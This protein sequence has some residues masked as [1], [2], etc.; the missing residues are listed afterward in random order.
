M[1]TVA[2]LVL[3]G[4]LSRLLPHPPNFV[5]LGALALYSGARLPRGRAWVVP[6]AA[7]AFSDFFLDFGSGRAIVSAVRLT[8]YATFAAIVL[9]GRLARESP[10][11]R[12][13]A[14]LSVAASSLFF[15]TTNFAEWLT[16]PL[17]A[18]TPGGLLA[19][20]AAAIPFFWNTLAADLFGTAVLFGLDALT[21]RQRN[22]RL[23][24][25]VA[26]VAVLALARPGRLDAQALPPASES[27]VVTAT[28]SPEEEKDLG[29]ATTVITRQDIEKS[30]RVTVVELLRSVPALDVVQS[31]SDG[32][33]TSIFLRGTNSTQTLVLV[34]GARVNSAYFPGYDFSGL[35]TENVERI[36]IARGPFS[37]LYGSD[38]IGGVIQI[39]TRPTGEGF[40]GSAAAEGGN[41]GTATASAFLSGSAGPFSAA[42]S[43]RYGNTNGDVPNSNWRENNGSARVG[44]QPGDGVRLGLEGSILSGKVGNPGPIGA[45]NP[46]A[47]GVFREERIALPASLALSSTNHLEGFVA[48]VWSKPEYDDPLGGY[49]SQTDARTLQAQ[50]TDTATL[51]AHTLTAIAMWNRSNVTNT[52]TFG[53]N[54]DGQST[55]IWGIGAQDSVTVGH[56]TVS[57]GIRYD[58]NSQFGGAVSPRGSVSWL[59]KDRRWKVR[60]AGGTGFRAPTV[61][62][63][64]YPYYGNP[65]LQPERSVSWEIGAEA[66]LGSG[67]RAEV[68]YFWNDL[69]DLIVYDFA[70]ATT[71]NIGRARTRGI[72]IGYRQQIVAALAIQATYTYLDAVDRADETPLP[73]RPRNRGSLT[74]LWQ[75][76]TSLSIEARALWVGSRPDS[77]PIT[78]AAV[79][80]PA[81]FRLDLFASWRLGGVSPYLRINNLTDA[82]YDEAAGYPAAGIRAG[83]GVEVKF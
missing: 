42:A 8:V 43:Y 19:C 46:E 76:L 64:Y 66:Y 16:D 45:Q 25:A 72:E 26:A 74:L 32:S 58:G 65:D 75:P 57:G 40:S 20:Y 15:L 18:G 10:R 28:A 17:Y 59:S 48:S 11:P 2:L 23:A 51:G 33:L 60:A 50:V 39:F 6:V 79:V 70:S 47:Y 37:A 52:D 5:A 22:R 1:T 12:H 44:W 68:T 78:S 35:T 36:E 82:S 41:A 24:A 29:V 81:Y 83:G 55:T 38:A 30:G 77:D 80:D 53:T 13:L 56:F 9:A 63:L 34:D 21:G 27:V 14:V 71:E 7:M 62:E 4:A 49:S 67:G 3:L 69:K 54:L 73:R 61:G 31:G